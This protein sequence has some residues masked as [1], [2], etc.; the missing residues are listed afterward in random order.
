M[1][2]Q[3]SSYHQ[4]QDEY[5]KF[6]SLFTIAITIHHGRLRPTFAITLKLPHSA[7]AREPTAQPRF[8]SIICRAICRGCR[9]ATTVNLK[10]SCS[11]SDSDPTRH[12]H[13]INSI[14]KP[15]RHL[16]SLNG[17]HTSTHPILIGILPPNARLTITASPPNPPIL[18]T[19]IPHH[20]PPT[21]PP[22]IRPTHLLTIKRP[23]SLP[24]HRP[25][26]LSIPP[27]RHGS[28]KAVHQVRDL[29]W[30]LC[31]LLWE[32]PACACYGAGAVCVEGSR[33]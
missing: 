26:R 21:S 24:V 32:S 7:G 29:E 28:P 12:L 2:L 9:S 17:I 30:W 13:L 25:P 31:A 16:H 22:L 19:D 15:N 3:S 33:R 4:H 18:P 1:T 20:T 14:R 10:L 6:S 5:G 23:P 11:V 8:N 27:L